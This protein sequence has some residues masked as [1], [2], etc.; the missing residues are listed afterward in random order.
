MRNGA[1]FIHSVAVMHC[2]WDFLWT[3]SLPEKEKE[4]ATS[5]NKPHRSF[6]ICRFQ[7]SNN[8]DAPLWCCD[9]ITPKQRS[10]TSIPSWLMLRGK[11]AERSLYTEKMESTES[12]VR[13]RRKWG[14]IWTCCWSSQEIPGYVPVISTRIRSVQRLHDPVCFAWN[15]QRKPLAWGRLERHRSAKPWMSV[16]SPLMLTCDLCYSEL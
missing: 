8:H 13:G 1:I 2:I 9:H 6:I 10:Y 14:R 11:V 15:N 16:S 4:K 7:P 5:Q 12:G 3:R